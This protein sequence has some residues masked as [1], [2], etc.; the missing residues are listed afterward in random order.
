[1]GKG[2][3][4]LIAQTDPKIV[5]NARKKAEAILLDIHLS[6]VR[7]L[8]QKTQVDVA[9]ALAV[10][11]PTIAELEKS[12]KDMRL[13]SLKKYIEAIGGKARIDVELPD[14]THYGFSL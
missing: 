10:S 11:Q 5:A 13:S 4:A 6:E 9:T 3:D 8:A 2:L 14:G 1:M 12:G 7:L